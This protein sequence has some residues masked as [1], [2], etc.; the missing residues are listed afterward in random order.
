MVVRDL[1][2]DLAY[3]GTVEVF[4]DT[5]SPAELL[6]KNVEVFQSSTLT[7]LYE[8]ERVYLARDATKL[9]IEPARPPSRGG[10]DA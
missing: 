6:L 4:S 9:V 10:P 3:A 7:K 8:A 1:P 2:E 5:S